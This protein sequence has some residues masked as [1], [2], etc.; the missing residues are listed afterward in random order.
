MFKI[1]PAKFKIIP[2]NSLSGRGQAPKISDL[3]NFAPEPARELS[4]VPG[5]N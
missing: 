4:L 1:I 3:K 2:A 5:P